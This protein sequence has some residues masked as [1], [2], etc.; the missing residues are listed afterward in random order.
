MENSSP[1][2]SPVKNEAQLLAPDILPREIH[3]ASTTCTRVPTGV[4]GA[5]TTSPGASPRRTSTDS[6]PTR[7]SVTGRD[8]TRPPSTTA[9][10][11]SHPAARH[12]RVGSAT[13]NLDPRV[14]ALP[15]GEVGREIVDRDIHEQLV[16]L[17]VHFATDALHHAR[18]ASVTLRSKDEPD[19]LPDRETSE[20]RLIH[21]R[22][23]AHRVR[24]DDGEGRGARR[25]QLPRLHMTGHDQ[26]RERAREPTVGDLGDTDPAGAGSDC[27]V[28]LCLTKRRLHRPDLGLCARVALA[29][30]LV[31]R[32]VDG[33]RSQ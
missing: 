4:P 24:C 7:P 17:A 16:R 1:S 23:H 31:I 3:G 6:R 14:R 26:T 20:R 5:R 22:A 11:V 29:R 19:G 2:P 30:G 18:E 9:H 32:P 33:A 13:A 10:S 21:P 15:D 28:R 27:S 8:A 25:H 12:T